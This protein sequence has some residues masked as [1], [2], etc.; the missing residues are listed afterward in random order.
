[1]AMAPMPEN[2]THRLDVLRSLDILDSPSELCFNVAVLLAAKALKAPVATVS[3]VDQ[4]R[5]WFKAI[6][7]LDVTETPRELAFC[8]HTILGHEPLVVC[9]ALRDSRFK[10]NPLVTHA[11]HVR[12]YVGMPLRVKD[13]NVGALCV[14]DHVPRQFGRTQLTLLRKLAD[15]VEVFLTAQG[16]R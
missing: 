5:Q 11:P 6:K 12:S 13:A 1:M 7:G 9:D 14:I 2:E 16:P 3:L 4:D 10:H 8:A 15:M